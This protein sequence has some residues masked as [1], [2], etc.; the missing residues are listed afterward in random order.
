M[1]RAMRPF[2]SLNVSRISVRAAGTSSLGVLPLEHAVQP[3]DVVSLYIHAIPLAEHIAD[4]V[5]FVALRFARIALMALGKLHVG[6]LQGDAAE[7]VRRVHALFYQDGV[8][9]RV[10]H[11]P[12]PLGQFLHRPDG[13]GGTGNQPF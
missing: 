2:I 3:G 7:N 4:G 1:A 5:G 8:L 9:L 13:Y 11:G 6:R 10:I 12:A